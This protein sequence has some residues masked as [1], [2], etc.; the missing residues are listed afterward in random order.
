MESAERY[1]PRPSRSLPRATTR[2]PLKRQRRRI[3]LLAESAA[4]PSFLLQ[5]LFVASAMSS[6]LA[7]PSSDAELN[8]GSVQDALTCNVTLYDQWYDS[9]YSGALLEDL[10][11]FWIFP[12]AELTNGQA[13]EVV[14][15]TCRVMMD[16]LRLDRAGRNG[17]VQDKYIY[18]V[19]CANECTLSDSIR[20]E[21]MELSSCTCLELSTQPSNPIYHTE[22]DWCVE[23]SGRMLCETF[24]QCGVWNCR[25]SDFMCPRYEY[26]KQTVP[27]RGK[28]D[29]SGA[30]KAGGRGSRKYATTVIPPLSVAVF[31][32]AAASRLGL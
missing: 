9:P 6:A 8:V 10:V 19:M 26:N 5:V 4:A 24:G 23:N 28:G 17:P 18:D 22:G 15:S 11:D 2:R 3:G 16:T 14:S 13:L 25:I 20:E 30:T 21:A 32:A 29:C 7:Q 12:D 31:V 1:L 27:H